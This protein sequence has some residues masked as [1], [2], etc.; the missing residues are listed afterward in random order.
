LKRLHI[1]V[2]NEGRKWD[3]FEANVMQAL[4]VCYTKK[5]TVQKIEKNIKDMYCINF[6]F[7]PGLIGSELHIH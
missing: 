2:E 4:K 7:S 5:I 6:V 3:K 1:K